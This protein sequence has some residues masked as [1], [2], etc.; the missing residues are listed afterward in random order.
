MSSLKEFITNYPIETLVD[1]LKNNKDMQVFN[2]LWKDSSQLLQIA[3]K[4]NWQ[5]EQD[6][7][8]WV[9]AVN[10]AIGKVDEFV[11]LIDPSINLPPY[12][13]LPT[14][15]WTDIHQLFNSQ[16]AISSSA[17]IHNS[18][19]TYRLLT[20]EQWTQVAALCPS[21]RFKH[22]RSEQLD[23]DDFVQIFRGWLAEK[24]YGNCAAGLIGTLHYFNGNMSGG[25]ATIG[26]ID[27]DRKVWIIEPQ[28]GKIYAPNDVPKLGGN[29]LANKAEIVLMIF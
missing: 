2:L 4:F 19:G 21:H 15:A 7:W 1:D 27:T 13:T 26:V 24:G 6:V 12:S 25:H 11:A 10:S 8:N 18:D 14:I 16:M 23:C 3:E 20:K 5:T 28:T 17:K 29:I 22:S 9:I